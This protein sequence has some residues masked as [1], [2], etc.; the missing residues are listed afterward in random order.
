MGAS[1]VTDELLPPTPGRLG[2]SRRYHL[3]DG[4]IPSESVAAD[5]TAELG[6]PVAV[7]VVTPVAGGPGAVV[8]RDR[9]GR[10]LAVDRGLVA[11]AVRKVVSPPPA[12]QDSPARRAL[13]AFDAAAT[14]EEKLAV[15]ADFLAGR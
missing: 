11:A 12:R 1:V 2:V 10:E 8:V 6:I 5:L 15:F 7:E 3:I 4:D 13:R 9:T 14:A